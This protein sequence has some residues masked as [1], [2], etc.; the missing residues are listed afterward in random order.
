MDP[1]QEQETLSE[2]EVTNFL[3]KPKSCKLKATL[4]NTIS[5]SRFSGR[6]KRGSN[7][8]PSSAGIT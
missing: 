7:P 6:R 5:A 8:Q 1:E 2:E 4:P 3:N